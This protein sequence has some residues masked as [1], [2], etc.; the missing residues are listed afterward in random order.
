M[1]TIKI[2]ISQPKYY[3]ENL[4]SYWVIK[5]Y[6]PSV[7]MFIEVYKSYGKKEAQKKLIEHLARGVCTVMEY[8]H[9]PLI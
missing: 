1:V 2:M 7:D 5:A 4:L 8:Y 9:L 3:Q 6:D